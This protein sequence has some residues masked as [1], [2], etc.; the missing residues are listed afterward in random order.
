MNSAPVSPLSEG[1]EFELNLSTAELK[2]IVENKMRVI[3]LNPTEA[4]DKLS[5]ANKLALSHLV[6]AS[7][8]LDDV[9]L[10]Q[11]HPDNIRAKKILQAETT[12]GTAGAAE[13]LT[14]FTIFNGLEGCDMYA[15]KTTPL[16]LFKSKKLQPGR[17]FFPQ[18]ITEAKLAAYLTAHPEQASAILGNNTIVCREGDRLIAEPYSVAFREEMEA[19]ARELFLAASATDHEG[20]AEYLRWHAQALVNDSDPEVMLNADKFWINLEDS[21]IEFTIGRETYMD[22]LSGAVASDPNVQAITKT[23]KINVKLK[24]SFGLRVGIVNPESREI[25]ADYCKE[26]DG[27]SLLMPLKEQYGKSANEVS[28]RKMHFVDVELVAFAGENAAV[29]TGLLMAQNLPNSDKLS[30]QLGEGSR[31]IFHRQ[32]RENYFDSEVQQKFLKRIVNTEQQ[33]LYDKTAD[34]KFIIG[35]EQGHSLGPKNTADGRDNKAALGKWGNILEENKADLISVVMADHFCAIGK[36]TVEQTNK[37]YLTWVVDELP[38]KQPSE[39]EAHRLRSVMQLNY[40]REKGAVIFEKSGQ[41]SIIPE[42]M[43]DV[44]RMM[45]ME[46]IALQLEGDAAKAE[47]FVNKYAAWNEAL[48][49][50]AD[51]WMGFNPRE[52]RLIRQPLREKLSAPDFAPGN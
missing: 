50:S 15:R 47:V 40:F 42:K 43:V 32:M 29:R 33:Y 9:F 11:D 26:L 39:E 14:L 20:L 13:A 48:Q 35:H 8:I 7:N 16:P 36:F 24:D 3:E 38:H 37:I 1:N 46:V 12:K 41:L 4:Y 45:L 2:D 10:K 17:G 51:T 34:F 22:C 28:E 18:N 6:K 23:N 5:V 44:A 19:A 25:I 52:Y 49:Y 31:L 30:N 27:F 21:P